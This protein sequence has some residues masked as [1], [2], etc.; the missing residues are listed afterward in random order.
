MFQNCLRKRLHRKMHRKKKNKQTARVYP[1]PTAGVFLF[2]KLPANRATA[3][4]AHENVFA[5]LPPP[6]GNKSKTGAHG[7]RLR[8]RQ[9]MRQPQKLRRRT[10]RQLRRESEWRE[11]ALR[12][13]ACKVLSP[14]PG[15][16]RRFLQ[17][18]PACKRPRRPNFR[19]RSRRRQGQAPWVRRGLKQSRGRRGPR[20]AKAAAAGRGCSGYKKSHTADKTWAGQRLPA[21]ENGY[22]QSIGGRPET[23]PVSWPRLAPA[24]G[25]VQKQKRPERNRPDAFVRG[26]I[27]AQ[28][29]L[30]TAGNI[31]L[32][33]PGALRGFPAQ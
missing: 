4:C 17:R 2:C 16:R 32:S 3:H 22:L 6:A 30:Y 27:P 18:N 15:G 20:S 8:P 26:I 12:A 31:A 11:D 14:K 29:R 24:G 10:F 1:R 5:R 13:A 9:G 19:A 21:K 23:L 7:K 33:A 25:S 28:T